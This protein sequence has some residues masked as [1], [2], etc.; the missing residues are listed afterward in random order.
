MENYNRRKSRA[1]HRDKRK[2]PTGFL[3]VWGRKL[4]VL[5]VLVGRAEDSTPSISR[6]RRSIVI[7]V[8]EDSELT[9]RSFLPST[10]SS[11]ALSEGDGAGVVSIQGVGGAE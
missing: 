6:M 10:P 3:L 7:K 11:A 9:L 5:Q 4:R 2:T 1:C 8:W